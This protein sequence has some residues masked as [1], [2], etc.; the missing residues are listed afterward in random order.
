MKTFRIVLLAFILIGSSVVEAY[1]KIVITI[2]IARHRDCE[3]LGFCDMSGKIGSLNRN[4]GHATADI[5]GAGKFTL[6]I[7]KNTDLTP[8]AFDKYFSKGVFICEDDYPVPGDILKSLG[9]T[10]NY[11]I[12]KGNYNIITSRDGTITITF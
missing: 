3:G 11:I 7:N 8:E 12:T 5:N 10:G 1:S 2:V 4:T 6:M 9:Y